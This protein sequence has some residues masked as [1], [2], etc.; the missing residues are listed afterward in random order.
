MGMPSASSPPAANAGQLRDA[1]TTDGDFTGTGGGPGKAKRAGNI[2]ACFPGGLSRRGV[3]HS[4]WD[5]T[6]LAA[7]P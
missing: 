5:V 1:A 4:G 2:G 7:I 6:S 3:K